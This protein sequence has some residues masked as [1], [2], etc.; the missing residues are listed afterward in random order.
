MRVFVHEHAAFCRGRQPTE[1]LN[2][3]ATRRA[4]RAVEI[5]HVLHRDAPRRDRRFERTCPGAGIAG[6]LR[7]FGQRLAVRLFDVLSRDSATRSRQ[8]RRVAEGDAR[9]ARIRRARGDAFRT[10]LPRLF[11][12][13][14]PLWEAGRLRKPCGVTRYLSIDSVEPSPRAARRPGSKYLPL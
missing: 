4:V 1:D 2:P 14:G 12:N 3:A 8:R 11:K 9:M 6:S 5:V 10:E 7:R 13:V